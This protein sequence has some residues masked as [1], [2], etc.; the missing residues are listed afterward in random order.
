MPF[1]HQLG[2]KVQRFLAAEERCIWLGQPNPTR[3]AM[4][5]IIYVVAGLVLGVYF[6][7]VI[8]QFIDT[9]TG[10]SVTSVFEY[11]ESIVPF[12]FVA[13]MILSPMVAYVSALGTI[14]VITDKRAMIINLS[15]FPR[16]T[17]SYSKFESGDLSVNELPHRSGDLFFAK[18][19]VRSNNN[20]FRTVRVGFLGIS[21]VRDV[22]SVFASVFGLETLTNPDSPASK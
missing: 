21:D 2:D 7:H 15:R 14:Y 1:T 13:C 9:P 3:I 12:L 20:V 5:Y 6:H 18:K 11:F 10:T 19:S 16:S 4:K 17:E 8:F 22:A